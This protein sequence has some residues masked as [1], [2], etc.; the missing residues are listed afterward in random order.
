MNATPDIVARFD[1]RRVLLVG[2]F[3]LDRYVFGDAERISPEAPV[4]VLRVIERQD[5]LGGA[6][7]VALNVLALD[8]RVQCV[9]LLGRDAFGDTVEKTL[10]A[11][12]ADVSGLI[13]A[14]DRSTITKTRLVGLAEH[15]HRQQILRVD[16]EVIKPPA[17][18]D[19]ARIVELVRAAIPACDV[20]CLEDYAKG[21]LADDVCSALIAVARAAGKPVLIDPSRAANWAKYRGA[22]LLTPNTAE[23]EAGLGR[24]VAPADLDN[25]G[26]E[27]ASRLDLDALVI[28]LGRDGARLVRRDGSAQHF[29]TRP[30]AVYDNT[31]AGDAVLAMM[32]VALAA[33]ATLE[34]AVPLA[35]IAGG[36]EVGKFGCVPIARQEVL[37]ELHARGRSGA[38]KLRTPAELETELQARRARGETVV[39]T[40]G[41]FDLLH[42]G[43]VELLQQA[44]AQGSLLVV[45][46]NS[47]ASVRAQA[48]GDD[49]PLRT[50]GDRARMLAAL[51]AVD[52]VVLFDEPSVLSLVRA[53]QP[54][55]IVKGGDYA[56]HEV[57]GHEVVLA[58]G[59]RVVVVPF[60]EGFSTTGELRRI[61][62]AAPG[63]GRKA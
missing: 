27:L 32:A 24:T 30:R 47:D 4:P 44:K 16:D 51:E 36:L 12:G 19:A 6:G 57:V 22:T 59:G 1:A 38:G 60:V 43:H 63:E 48:K 49:R 29:P 13:R 39:F 5:R 25:A 53:V 28:T 54:D 37:D 41:C 17:P 31:G 15:R 26:G 34:E 46:L 9:G 50:Q 21:V 58:R 23:F 55:V 52:Y 33:G 20:L 61:R 11:A 35:N 42:P 40:N 62:T 56:P 45:G 7:F 18:A 2:D 10:A 3:L 14:A 8:A